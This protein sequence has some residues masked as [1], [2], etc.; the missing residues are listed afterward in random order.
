MK[1]K[2]AGFEV[3][4]VDDEFWE[5]QDDDVKGALEEDEEKAEEEG[6]VLV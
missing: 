3:E 1:E 2:S 5:G 6:D 4:P